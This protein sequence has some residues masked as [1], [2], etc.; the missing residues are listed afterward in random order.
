MINPLK[1]L[2]QLRNGQEVSKSSVDSKLK[3]RINHWEWR[4]W[5]LMGVC[6]DFA[7]RFGKIWNDLGKF[8]VKMGIADR[9]WDPLLRI[10]NRRAPSAVASSQGRKKLQKV[11][12]RLAS[13]DRHVVS[14]PGL[15]EEWARVKEG[16]SEDTP[17][18]KRSL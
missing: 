9:L 16:I 15:I 4:V 2:Q 10:D 5:E 17:C 12:L 11:E 13:C 8:K 18:G 1:A 14:S 6:E 3:A 7:R